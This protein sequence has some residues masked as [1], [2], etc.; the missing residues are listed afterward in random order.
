MGPSTAPPPGPG[1]GLARRAGPPQGPTAAPGH[2]TG[3]GD[4][5]TSGQPARG[6]RASEPWSPTLMV[7]ASIAQRFLTANP[8]VGRPSPQ[9]VS[10]HSAEPPRRR[11]A[12]ATATRRSATLVARAYPGMRYC[13]R[14]GGVEMVTGRRH[15]GRGNPHAGQRR[16]DAWAACVQ[17]RADCSGAAKA[18]AGAR[19][20]SDGQTGMDRLAN[21]RLILFPWSTLGEGSLVARRR[22]LRSG[23]RA[24]GLRA[25]TKATGDP[26]CFTL[27][28]PIGRPIQSAH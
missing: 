19:P 17:P 5:G 10:L 28:A 25:S 11:A 22:H 21:H 18:R 6:R 1:A 9:R 27:R 2:A 7:T 4:E 13:T 16:A 24:A 14:A 26:I 20:R 8:G 12:W 3:T 23:R 15:G